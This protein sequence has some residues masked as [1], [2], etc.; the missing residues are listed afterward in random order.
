MLRKGQ[1]W[2]KF[3]GA[4]CALCTAVLIG[5]DPATAT[6]PPPIPPAFGLIYE[7]VTG[8]PRKTTSVCDPLMARLAE[9][10]WQFAKKAA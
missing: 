1:I 7:G 8:Q 9:L 4:P 10:A 2:S 3:F 5:W 6:H